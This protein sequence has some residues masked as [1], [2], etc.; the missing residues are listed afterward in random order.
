MQMTFTQYDEFVNQIQNFKHITYWPT[1]MDLDYMQKNPEHWI[2]FACYLQERNDA[3]RTN[4]D[5]YAK[6]NLLTFINNHLN[7]VD[8]AD[9]DAD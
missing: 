9:E 3:P 8:E 4:E 6:K 5:K 7:L 2:L 1:I